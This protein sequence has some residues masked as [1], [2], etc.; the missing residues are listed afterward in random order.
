MMWFESSKNPPGSGTD[1]GPVS[2]E[3]DER[4]KHAPR[5]ILHGMLA[6][7][8]LLVAGCGAFSFGKLKWIEKTDSDEKFYLLKQAYLSGG[9]PQPR[10]SFDHTILDTVYL[11]FV[12]ANEKGHYVTKSVWYDP[13]GAEFRTIRETHDRQEETSRG[14]ERNEK[15]GTT[16]MHSISLLDLYHHMPGRWKVKLYI[17]SDLARKLDFSVR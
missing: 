10:T 6:L 3:L 1:A 4:N 7:V 15:K 16:R 13:S 17:D 12:P 14:E 5:L 11:I 2:N 9:S 8:V